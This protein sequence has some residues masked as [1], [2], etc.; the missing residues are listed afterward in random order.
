MP[1]GKEN[2][3]WL[4]K[5]DE[6]TNL[7]YCQITKVGG[8]LVNKKCVFWSVWWHGC[9]SYAFKKTQSEY[10]IENAAQAHSINERNLETFNFSARRII[11]YPI[12]I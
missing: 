4:N 11:E 9:E 6:E 3:I 7:Y 12:G 10:Q 8:T 5:N 1:K 2:L